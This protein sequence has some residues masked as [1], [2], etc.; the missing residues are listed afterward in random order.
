[1]NYQQIEKKK[2]VNLAALVKKTGFND[3]KVSNILNRIYKQGRV[4]RADRGIYIS[5]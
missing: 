4:K 1:M 2:G 3:K 5:A